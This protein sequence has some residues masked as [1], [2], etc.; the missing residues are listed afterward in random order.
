MS[1]LMDLDEDYGATERQLLRWRYAG[2]VARPAVE[3][4]G[5]QRRSGV[6]TFSRRS[7]CLAMT[8]SWPDPGH[9]NRHRLP[10]GGVSPSGTRLRCDEPG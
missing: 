10:K 3:W 1:S 8:A 4:A 9:G 2:S 5:A 6:F 7:T